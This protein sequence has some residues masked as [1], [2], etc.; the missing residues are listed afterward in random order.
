MGSMKQLSMYQMAAAAAKFR[1]VSFL[2]QHC[3]V[4]LELW[5][6]LASYPISSQQTYMLVYGA[7]V[8]G[9]VSGELSGTF[10]AFANGLI[11]ISN[12][13]V[14]ITTFHLSVWIWIHLC[15]LDGL[16]LLIS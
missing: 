9:S 11:A 15:L 10:G 1:P 5:P 13:R 3:S 2:N 7:Q 12:L 14:S 8:M 16:S 6:E 4:F